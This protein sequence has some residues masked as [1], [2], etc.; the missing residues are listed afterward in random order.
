MAE[1]RAASL[2]AKRRKEIAGR[3]AATRWEAYY[4]LHPDK[5]KAKQERE[6]RKRRLVEKEGSK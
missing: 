5:L 1:A 4:K 3:A 2:T 6:A